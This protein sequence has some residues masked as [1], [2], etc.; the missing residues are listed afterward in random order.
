MITIAD[1]SQAARTGGC[2]SHNATVMTSE[3][4]KRISQVQPGDSVLSMDQEGKPVFS[5]VLMFLDKNSTETRE[6]YHV[7]TSS[8]TSLALTPS[9]LM[10]KVDRAVGDNFARTGEELDGKEA[11]EVYN[12]AEVTF[13]KHI[14]AGDWLLVVTED[15][16]KV[17]LEKVVHMEA[18]LST[19]VYAP[20]TKQGNVV[21]DGIL[22]SCYAVIDDQDLAH[23][24][25]SPVRFVV[26]MYEGIGHA[27]KKFSQFIT[28]RDEPFRK[29][30]SS[31][32]RSS[33]SSN[34]SSS[35]GEQ[36]NNKI[37]VRESDFCTSGKSNGTE[38]GVHWYA[39][40]LYSTTKYLLP[41]NLLYDHE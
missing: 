35:N 28:F 39:S 8:G 24:A 22:A 1:S 16:R 40:F 18:S 31:R 41:S 12:S 30:A 10:Y 32:S 19:G 33:S 7:T 26:N 34:S 5:E 6:F 3:G 37:L 20:L 29:S 13:A 9:H 38:Q 17:R 21:V 4:R 11:E 23:L 2:F 36:E 15:T 27:W 14:E 25:F